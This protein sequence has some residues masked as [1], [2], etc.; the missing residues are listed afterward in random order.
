VTL[1]AA[2]AA[3]AAVLALGASGSAQ[4][5]RPPT[6]MARDERVL[7]GL[8]TATYGMRLG[9][10]INLGAFGRTVNDPEPETYWIL[11]GALALAVPVGALLIE[12]RYPMRR[13]RG[14][15]AGA[16]GILG[17]LAATSIGTLVRDESVPTSATL[18][19]WATFIGTTSGLALGALVGHLTD[20]MPAD[21]LFAAT[22]G[23]GGALLGGLLCGA[24][25]CGPQLGAW[26]LA[27]ELGLFTTALLVRATVRPTLPTMRLVGAGALGLGLLMGGGVLLAH[28]VRDGELTATGVQRSAVFG[29]GGLV[30]GA[31]TFFAIGR[32]AESTTT[33]IPTAQVA[34]SSLVLGV[35]VT[36]P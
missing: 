34:G 36:H 35:S 5:L 22:G 20:A 14:L 30:V 21:A 15:S 26:S 28:G 31:V 29:L 2:W 12:R 11:P 7:F 25:R 8:L 24:A 23:V 9:T 18:A 16:G 6:S 1:R 17:Y 10:A 4:T 33:V 3:G 19:G 27:G 32:R 13:G